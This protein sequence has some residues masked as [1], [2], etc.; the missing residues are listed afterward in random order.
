MHI[1]IAGN[2]GSGKSTVCDI[3]NSKYGFDIYSTGKIQR[4]LAEKMNLTTLEMN[5]LMSTDVKYDHLID[6]EVARISVEKNDTPIVFDSR[7][8]WLFAK[9]SFKVYL[10][11]DPAVAAERVINTRT[12]SVESYA[13]VEDAVNQ[14]AE[15]TRVE[16]ERFKNI[17]NVDNLNHS[18]YDLIVDTSVM[19]PEQIA[20]IIYENYKKFELENNYA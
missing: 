7:M 11:I 1:T 9:N 6:D 4:G 5:K 20:D 10:T 16:N 8:A 2:L 19:L 3:L 17:Y 14:L 15:R 13:S 18:N 12:S